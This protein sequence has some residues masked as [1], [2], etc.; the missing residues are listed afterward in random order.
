[1]TRDNGTLSILLPVKPETFR[2]VVDFIWFSVCVVIEGALVLSLAGLSAVPG[3]RPVLALLAL[4]FFAAGLF[5][6]YRLLWYWTGAERF[7]ISAEGLVIERALLGLRR[8]RAFP[9]EEIRSI[10][11]RRMRYLVIYPSW[12]RMLI[13]HGPAEAVVQLESGSHAFGKG[14]E[15]EEA[16]RLAEL[17]S[18]ELSALAPRRRPSEIRL[19]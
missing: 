13:G 3:P 9:R 14:L 7:V 4:A 5:L 6:L 12:G 10:R 8:G 16:E 11:A 19:G 17:L 2:W 18:A 15:M 1:M